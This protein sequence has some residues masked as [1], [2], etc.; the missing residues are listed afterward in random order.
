MG[1]LKGFWELKVEVIIFKGNTTMNAC[2]HKLNLRTD[3]EMDLAC[4]NKHLLE[5]NITFPIPSGQ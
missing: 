2:T 3:E 5:M 1:I 4:Y